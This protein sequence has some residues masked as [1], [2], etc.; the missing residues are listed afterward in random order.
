ME[1]AVQLTDASAAA[2][3]ETPVSVASED[4]LVRIT[5][6]SLP[7]SSACPD[8][9]WTADPH[10]CEGKTIPLAA[11]TGVL[12]HGAYAAADIRDM[13][14]ASG[15]LL[16]ASAH[17]ILASLV[18]HG[19]YL[20]APYAST[21]ALLAAVKAASSS[22]GVCEDLTIHQEDLFATQTFGH[23][24]ASLN[25]Q[26]ST[27]QNRGVATRSSSGQGPQAEP[28]G[29][30]EAALLRDDAIN[31]VSHLS[32]GSLVDAGGI[33][34]PFGDLSISCGPYYRAN[35]RT[36]GSQFHCI[37]LDLRGMHPPEIRRE[38]LLAGLIAQNWTSSMWPPPLRNTSFEPLANQLDV[39]ARAKFASPRQRL[40]VLTERFTILLRTLPSLEKIC[41]NMLPNE[42]YAL[43]SPMSKQL[44]PLTDETSIDQ[45]FEL[46]KIVATWLLT[47]DSMA[48]LSTPREKVQWIVEKVKQLD[49]ANKL[50]PAINPASAGKAKR[51]SRPIAD[52]VHSSLMGQ[53]IT[54][55]DF[56]KLW[57]T[58]API[59]SQ[60]KKGELGECLDDQISRVLGYCFSNDD[61]G[62]PLIWVAQWLVS[63]LT[64]LPYHLFFTEMIVVR[65]KKAIYLGHAIAKDASGIQLEGATGFVV[66]DEIVTKM[67]NGEFDKIH[68]YNELVL[69]LR[70]YVNQ[71]RE[72]AIEPSRMWRETEIMREV[73]MVGSYLFQAYGFG[74]A[75]KDNSFGSLIEKCIVFIQSAATPMK[76]YHVQKIASNLPRILKAAGDTF[77][78]AM[79]SPPTIDF[80]SSFL[81]P[82]THAAQLEDLRINTEASK[83]MTTLAR[84]Y[85]GLMHQLAAAAVDPLTSFIPQTGLVTQYSNKSQSPKPGPPSAKRNTVG[86]KTGQGTSKPGGNPA[87]PAT[88]GPS[89][90]KPYIS[91]KQSQAAKRQKP[92]TPED[93]LGLA[94]HLVKENQSTVSI[95]N[96]KTGQ[97]VRKYNKTEMAKHL[98]CKAEDRCW[99]VGVSIKTYPQNLMMCNN[100]NHKADDPAH[101]FPKGFSQ[102]VQNPPFCLP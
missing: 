40:S 94:S 27:S 30:S 78:E 38:Q 28:S 50:L 43:L 47:V 81:N 45:F 65:N 5:D 64:A 46:D 11:L 48:S 96:P 87:Q 59:I 1:F 80:P 33:L 82:V 70:S 102:Q 18:N 73:Q 91:G 76:T 6:A 74:S 71:S 68:F 79:F 84:A 15:A 83:Q 89:N 75:A 26:S 12:A 98:K 101:Q 51:G 8:L 39:N 14:I 63:D 2:A 20:G 86:S 4:F 77:V 44:V 23:A 42:A 19:L 13:S 66:T 10:G 95:S 24:Q 57:A 92:S 37:M 22:A 56:I 49:K 7:L 36:E 41:G 3:L 62:G 52:K 100:R 35:Q 25:S 90:S 53:L 72:K 88:Q 9:P 34:A 99:P 16:P 61:E 93:Y 21:D 17:R 67:D 29:D 55:T 31:F 69:P 60:I 58:V 32:F 97:I 85:P 54:S